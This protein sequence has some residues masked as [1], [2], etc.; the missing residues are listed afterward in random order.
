MFAYH[1]IAYSCFISAASWDCHSKRSSLRKTR[2][3]MSVASQYSSWLMQRQDV[4]GYGRARIRN[5]I[6]GP[7][8]GFSLGGR[9]GFADSWC[10][11]LSPICL[12]LADALGHLMPDLSPA[13]LPLVFHL[14]RSGNRKGKIAGLQFLF[15]FYSAWI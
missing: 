6:G 8:G 11:G 3:E 9:F 4:D 12:P 1:T 7:R 14:N 5:S 10:W 2:F 15:Q 13:C